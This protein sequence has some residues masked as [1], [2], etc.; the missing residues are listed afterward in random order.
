MAGPSP[1]PC[2]GPSPVRWPP[3]SFARWL[4]AAGTRYLLTILAELPPPDRRISSRHRPPAPDGMETGAGLQQ[5]KRVLRCGSWAVTPEL[6]ETSPSAT[7]ANQIC[8]GLGERCSCKEEAKEAKRQAH[9][10][11]R[12]LTGGAWHH[13]QTVV[14][15][16][17]VR[18]WSVDHKISVRFMATSPPSAA[19]PAVYPPANVNFMSVRTCGRRSAHNHAKRRRTQPGQVAGRAIFT[20]FDVIESRHLG[21]V[22]PSKNSFVDSAANPWLNC[23]PSPI[24]TGVR[25]AGGEHP[26][27]GLRSR[28]PPPASPS[29]AR[30]GATAP[31]THNLFGLR[32]EITFFF[33]FVLAQRQTTKRMPCVP[34]AQMLRLS[35]LAGTL[36]RIST[37][38]NHN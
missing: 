5:E 6:R 20:S 7:A 27:P 30:C 4:A 8:K 21:L 22:P 15:L 24:K 19:Q 3:L 17:S 11:F 25:P 36:V 32:I 34:H 10:L 33:S 38:Q 2:Q 35:L 23:T 14:R 37:S 16:T 13:C 26:D 18:L 1:T 9:G 28:Y 29:L 12:T 31:A